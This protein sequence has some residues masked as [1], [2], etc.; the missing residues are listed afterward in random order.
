M[1]APGGKV[2]L[3]VPAH[4][5]SWCASDVLA[6]HWR[7]YNRGQFAALATGAGCDVHSIECYGW[8]LGNLTAGVRSW[9]DAWK[10][11]CTRTRARVHRCDLPGC[12]PALTGR[13][14]PSCPRR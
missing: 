2:L 14:S 8:P 11:R 10:L 9:F 13:T 3:S 4:E 7:R 6:G 1:I 5:A 12:A